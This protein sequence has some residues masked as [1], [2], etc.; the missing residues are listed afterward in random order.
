MRAMIL[1]A[2]LGT[3]LRPLTFVR[4]KCLVPLNGITVLD[5]W[6]KRLHLFGFE[7]VVIN[8]FHL[9]RAVLEWVG[10]RSWPIHVEVVVEDKLL[11]TGGGIRNVLD[12]FDG[13]PF[14]VVNGDTVCDVP[15]DSLRELYLKSGSLMALLM[16]D[17]LP[18]NNVRVDRKGFV[19]GFGKETAGGFE[20]TDCLAFT[21]I[22][23][24]T[25]E[26]ISTIPSGMPY[27]ILKIFCTAI[28]KGLFPLALQLPAFYWR[29]M[30]SVE[31]Y[32]ALIA[33][34]ARVAP[35]TLPPLETGR[36]VYCH[37]GSIVSSDAHIKGWASIGEGSQVMPH[38]TIENSILWNDVQVHPGTHLIDCVVGDGVIVEGKHYREVLVS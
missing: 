8:A 33:D 7:A 38:T 9:H 31:S 1:A 29:E 4:P 21:G 20:N 11:G 23:F 10:A 5:F 24:L 17:C 32:R 26:I 28:E 16:H 27:D 19:R 13:D 25:P 6:I 22:Y 2:G 37:P 15:L 3:R 35:G 14:L 18:F 12:F 36:S 30:G 34:L